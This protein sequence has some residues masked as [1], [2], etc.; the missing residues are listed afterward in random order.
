MIPISF[1][2]RGVLHEQYYYIRKVTKEGRYLVQTR[3]QSKSG[4]VSLPEA[5]GVQK[6]IDPHV[7]LGI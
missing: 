4:G 5:H 1:N 3:L 7:K 2:M 6:S